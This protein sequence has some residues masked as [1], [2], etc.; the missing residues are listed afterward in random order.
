M[1]STYTK[2][3]VIGITSGEIHN[4]IE[5]WSPVAYGQS[6]TYVDCVIAAGGVPLLLPLTT[7]IALLHQLSGMLDGLLL[8]GGNDLD[9]KLYGQE[10]LSTTNDY[11]DLRDTTE[12]ILMERAL[13]DQ[14][15]ILGIC[16]GMQLLNVHFGGT[17]H[18][19]LTASHPGLDHDGSTK[20]KSLV[21]LSHT[22][23][24]KPDSKLAQIVGPVSIGAN[25][26]HHQ[27]I[28][29]VGKG[30]QANAWAEDGVIEGIE[31]INYPYAVCIQAHPESL[32]QAE[33]R[34]AR[35]FAAFVAAA[36]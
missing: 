29:K 36:R 11:S 7:D 33:P 25:A 32:T 35:L 18:Q 30:M 5:T 15:P 34:W 27:A 26:H 14:K 13:A 10:P 9:P 2:K 20:L 23:T 21:D 17:L 8:A 16:R 19:D 6:K 31:I 28:D 3:P 1:D 4:K 22:F 24:V 12:Q